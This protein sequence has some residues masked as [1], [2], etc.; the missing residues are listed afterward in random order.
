[1]NIQKPILLTGSHR[2]GSTWVGKIL[3]SSREVGYLMEPFNLTDRRPGLVNVHFDYWFQYINDKN[4][5]SYYEP[6]K[7]MLEFQYDLGVGL[8]SVGSGREFLKLGRDYYQCMKYRY[9]GARPLVKQPTSIFMARWFYETFNSDIIV[10]IRHPAAFISSLMMLQWRH[11]FSEFLQQPD[12]MKDYLVPFEE[13]IRLYSIKEQCLM[14]QAILLWKII[15][16]TI[17]LYQDKYNDWIFMRHE[18]LSLNGTA[19]FEALFSRLNIP[20]D[21]R[22]I[23]CINKYGSKTNPADS[24]AVG[25]M[26]QTDKAIKRDSV[27]NVSNW[28]KRLTEREIDHIRK[29]VEDISRYFYTDNEW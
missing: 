17:H 26:L 13:E 22:V 4:S 2:S 12:L 25:L 6:I 15:H 29:N 20:V 16:H 7:K 14:D 3:S 27:A 10:L 28:K 18:D 9:S 8:S 24:T 21:E 19:E 5:T 1:M 23:Q 11:P